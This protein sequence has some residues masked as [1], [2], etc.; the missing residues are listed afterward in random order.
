MRERKKQHFGSAFAFQIGLMFCLLIRPVN[1]MR[2][3]LD[4]CGIFSIHC[5][6][7]SY[8]IISIDVSSG[9]LPKVQHT[10]EPLGYSFRSKI[11]NKYVQSRCC[12]GGPLGLRYSSVLPFA[13]KLGAMFFGEF[14]LIQLE[15]Q[16]LALSPFP[17]F[18]IFDA[19]NR[20]RSFLSHGMSRPVHGLSACFHLNQCHLR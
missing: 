5:P 12:F 8:F 7:P 13:N 11:K 15:C 10:L 19:L 16:N 3:A 2:Y 18:T 9:S 14:P 17:T 1:W 20:S 6:S 4:L